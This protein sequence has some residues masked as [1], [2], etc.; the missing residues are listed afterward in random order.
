MNGEGVG[1]EEYE[2]DRAKDSLGHAEDKADRRKV[3]QVDRGKWRRD[4]GALAA[5]IV[6]L[7]GVGYYV[8]GEVKDGAE[9]NCEDLRDVQEVLISR[10]EKDT[11][12]TE[13]TPFKAATFDLT[14]DEFDRLIARE[15]RLNNKDVELLR[16][17]ATSCEERLG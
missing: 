15:V 16:P 8:G 13:S 12:E 11:R 1:R 5:L 6:A 17:P 14:E 4:L 10:I 7:I 2:S 3:A 9:K